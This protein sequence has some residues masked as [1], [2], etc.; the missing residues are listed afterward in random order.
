MKYT[1]LGYQQQKLIDYG[2]TI[3]GAYI[4]RYLQDVQPIFEK[5]II[6][7][8]EYFWVV[9]SQIVEEYPLVI[10]TIDT[11]K[12]HMKKLIAAGFIEKSPVQKDRRTVID[13]KTVISYGKFSYFRVTEKIAELLDYQDVRD[14][15]GH[16]APRGWCKMHHGDRAKCTI[17]DP[18]TNNPST[19]NHKDDDVANAPSVDQ[20]IINQFCSAWTSSTGKRIKLTDNQK[21]LLASLIS[22]HGIDIVI[23]TVKKMTSSTYLMSNIKPSKFLNDEI[24][25]KIYNG[26]YDDYNKVIPALTK[27]KSKNTHFTTTYSHNWNIS[28]L[29]ERERQYVEKLYGDK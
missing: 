7:G 9:Q 27:A 21:T 20:S 26:E 6:R 14:T 11:V 25:I 10:K 8:K 3:E 4:L 17:K 5:R 12:R 24:F 28:E 15:I 2:I 19:N 29:E 16:F 1:V 23:E 18:S 22:K 13:G